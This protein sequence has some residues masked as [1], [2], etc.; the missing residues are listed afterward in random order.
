[1][2]DLL[3]GDPALYCAADKPKPGEKP[4]AVYLS[5]LRVDALDRIYRTQF[6]LSPSDAASN[7]ASSFELWSEVRHAS[8]AEHLAPSLLSTLS[9]LRSLRTSAGLPL[10]LGSVTNGNADPRLVP[11]LSSLFDFSVKAEDVGSL[12]PCPRLFSSALSAA[13]SLAPHLPKRLGPWWVH[14]GD[15]EVRDAEGA[16][17][18]GMRTILARGLFDKDKEGSS[19]GAKKD[20]GVHVGGGGREKKRGDGEEYCDHVV[21]HFEHIQHVI[22]K[23]MKDARVETHKND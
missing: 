14:I 20:D 18:V 8:I 23:W 6:C 7:A 3:S 22:D 10:L 5:R 17:A 2:R 15:D 12:K 16:K 21:G 11:C 4:E 1:M 9:F 19:V 13:S